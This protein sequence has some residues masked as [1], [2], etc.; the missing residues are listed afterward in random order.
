MSY[1]AIN[2]CTVCGKELRITCLHCTECNT[3]YQ[4]DFHFDKFSYLNTQ[5]K[6]F[7]EI[8]LRCRGNIRE[9]EKE[10][11]ISYPTVR[12]RLDDVIRALGY[13][14]PQENP[15][16]NQKEIID[17]LSKG[18]ISYDQAMKMMKSKD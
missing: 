2:K 10:L 11:G 14:L 6:Q 17:S 1:P 15:Q 9:V 18:E 12:S 7:I 5:Q 16:I 4:G 8:F 13:E 3:Q